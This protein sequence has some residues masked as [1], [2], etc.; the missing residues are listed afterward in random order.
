METGNGGNNEK[1]VEA[2]LLRFHEKRGSLTR[3]LMGSQLAYSVVEAEE[4]VSKACETLCARLFREPTLEVKDS[5]FYAAVR[6]QAFNA[7]R[8]RKVHDRKLAE[9]ASNA[10]YLE[11]P[12]DSLDQL[13]KMETTHNWREAFHSLLTK[14]TPNHR[15]ILEVR[16]LEGL[17]YSEIAQRLDIRL[18]TVMSRLSRAHAILMADF[19]VDPKAK[20]AALEYWDA[21]GE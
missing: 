9:Q 12:S 8:A 2:I 16:H 13:I 6:N 15:Q 11:G 17:S 7:K 21:K 18:G 3:Y 14:L 20:A 1:N 19:E 5:Y 10:L 4:L